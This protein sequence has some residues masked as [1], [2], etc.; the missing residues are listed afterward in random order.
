MVFLGH[1]VEKGV[2][3]GRRTFSVEETASVKRVQ[4]ENA[5]WGVFPG[6]GAVHCTNA[7][8]VEQRGQRGER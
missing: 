2:K 3:G 6:Q 5:G 8:R 1:P 7:E 4:R